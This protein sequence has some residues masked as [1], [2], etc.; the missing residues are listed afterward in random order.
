MWTPSQI[1]KEQSDNLPLFSCEQVNA[2]VNLPS[3]SGFRH[4][5]VTIEDTG[6]YVSVLFD[7]TGTAVA[8]TD[9]L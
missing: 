9:A 1:T 2:L 5:R 8:M 3:F 7:A 4:L 6:I